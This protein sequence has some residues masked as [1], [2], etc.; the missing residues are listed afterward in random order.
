[1][2]AFVLLVKNFLGNLKAKNYIKLL[3]MMLNNFR[4]LECNMSILIYYVHSYLDHFPENLRNI[5]E[6]QGVRLH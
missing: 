3:K 4:D 5:S 2:D 1:M 6:K